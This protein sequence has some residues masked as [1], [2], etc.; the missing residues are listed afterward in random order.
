MTT[1]LGGGLNYIDGVYNL[2]STSMS[3]MGCHAYWMGCVD[4][5]IFVWSMNN[6]E[7]IESLSLPDG[8]LYAVASS[9]KKIL[10]QDL[11]WL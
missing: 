9:L 7:S 4:S 2:T 6:G 8:T 1:Y 11:G 10:E 5:E 3:D